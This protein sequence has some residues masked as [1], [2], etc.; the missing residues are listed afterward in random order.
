MD[1]CKR[2]YR[3]DRQRTGKE[4]R[5]VNLWTVSLTSQGKE[6]V[7]L[8]FLYSSGSFSKPLL[9]EKNSIIGVETVDGTHHYADKVI[10]A[11]GAYTPALIDLEDQCVAKV[12]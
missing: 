9:D 11:G 12:Y 2:R 5:Q 6:H 8:T 3:L 7:H 1:G 10:I 4:R